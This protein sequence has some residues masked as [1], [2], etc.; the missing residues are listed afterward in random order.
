MSIKE[1]EIC[2]NQHREK[3]IEQEFKA[4]ESKYIEMM[5]EKEKRLDDLML[6]L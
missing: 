4:K 2:K 1:E 6:E 3:S 5:K